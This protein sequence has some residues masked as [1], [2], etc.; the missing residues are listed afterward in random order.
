MKIR[1]LNWS[2]ENLR[3]G[4]GKGSVELR[5]PPKQWSLVQ[6]PNGTGKTSTMSL[7]RAILAEKKM[8][9][10]EVRG[11]RSNNEVQ[12]GYF[13]LGLLIDSGKEEC[14][15][16]YLRA[17][18]DFLTGS[19][20]FS[21][22]R[23][24]ER[25]G[26]RI[27]G[28]A[29]PH[30]L[31]RL[32]SLDFIK[33]FVFDGEL[34]SEIRNTG[35]DEADRAIRTLYQLDDINILISDTKKNVSDIQIDRDTNS[36]TKKGVNRARNKFDEA[37]TILES[38]IKEHSEKHNRKLSLEEE[39]KNIEIKIEVYL[40]QDSN[41]K[42]EFEKLEKQK[43]ELETE[44]HVSS[45][46]AFD[47]FRN[48]IQLSSQFHKHLTELG[49]LLTDAKLPRSPALEFF[50]E[51][52][53]G[54]NCICGNPIGKA[55][56][57]YLKENF[58]NY[59]ADDQVSA[60]A[61][62]K[63]RLKSITKA[64]KNF[65]AACRQ[66]NNE[67]EKLKENQRYLEKLEDDLII[68]GNEETRKL[69]ELVGELKQQI[70]QLDNEINKLTTRSRHKQEELKCT[71]SNNIPLAEQ[72]KNKAEQFYKEASNS[73]RLTSQSEKLVRVLEAIKSGLLERLR[74]EIRLETNKR[75]KE[76]IL[77]ENLEVSKIE[78]SLVLQSDRVGVRENVSEGQ[79]L[80]VA[81]AF[82][83]S[84]LENAPFDLPFV[85]DSP[86]V[87]LDLEVR[88]EVARTLPK[89][90]KQMILFVI[91]SEGSGFTETFYDKKE[92]LFVSFEKNINGE[93][94]MSYGLDS[95]KRIAAKEES[96]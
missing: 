77:M 43:N 56:R 33:L 55:E 45:R 95:F 74:E 25:D 86:A 17:E 83:T 47:A 5:N 48:P 4:S 12:E 62:M 70:E 31:K 73:Y 50:Q 85:V 2:Y 67:K 22:L 79:S 72:N 81:Y 57:Q 40:K 14:L 80:S 78:G 88:A 94:A 20:N 52:A 58:E 71:A 1:I 87:S 51:I 7:I 91:S 54:E 93:I 66:L 26:G 37:K 82:L 39:K 8:S 18:F 27:P 36:K 30:D 75:L 9:K 6:M 41:L 13:E 11:Y 61:V 64:E 35:K 89:L 42:K 46:T 53:Q 59:L 3:I 76:L 24:S 90:F 65:V 32:L 10:D 69:S 96:Q 92:A 23:S 84:L 63:T 44:I 15:E 19:C 60:I 29:I 38:L 21:T 68:N 34:A 49:T 16:Y 28:I